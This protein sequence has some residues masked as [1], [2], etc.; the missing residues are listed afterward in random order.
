MPDSCFNI[1]RAFKK[2]KERGY[3]SLYFAI[4]LHDVII[5]GT[6]TRN[7][8]GKA[9]YPDA[10]EVLQWISKHHKIILWTSSHGG[11]IGQIIDWLSVNG[12]GVDYINENPDFKNSEL[13]DFSKKFAFDILLD[14]KAGFDGKTDWTLI[15][16]KLIEIG[17]WNTVVNL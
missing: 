2:G 13:N 9:F 15:K 6:Y 10:K 1:E 12:I 7:N 16:N 14:D 11:P 8:E 4:D 3:S 5:P 17:E